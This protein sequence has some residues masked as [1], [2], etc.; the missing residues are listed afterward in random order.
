[1]KKKKVEIGIT[2]DSEKLIE[3]IEDAVKEV[4]LKDKELFDSEVKTGE[5]FVKS[6]KAK[7]AAYTYVE[8]LGY[9][10]YSL[11]RNTFMYLY[12]TLHISPLAL[13]ESTQIRIVMEHIE[14]IFKKLMPCYAFNDDE[15]VTFNDENLARR[16][17]KDVYKI[18]KQ[19]IFSSILKPIQPKEKQ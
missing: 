10:G 1:M 13:T 19:K 18:V 14:Y 3:I 12:N 4:Y 5:G 9:K 6:Y 15:Y 16:F 17:C 8:E 7:A 11:Q 2:V